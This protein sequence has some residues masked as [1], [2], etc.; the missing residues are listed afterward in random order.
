MVALRGSG[1]ESIN[2]SMAA[3]TFGPLIRTIAIP[4]G[5]APLETAKI[6]GT[7]TVVIPA[8]SLH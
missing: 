2:V 5:T 1:N 7:L 3:R 6:V 4:A 8:T